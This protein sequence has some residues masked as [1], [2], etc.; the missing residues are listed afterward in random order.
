MVIL[1]LFFSFQVNVMT[2]T[3]RHTRLTV[4][5]MRR[6]ANTRLMTT[7]FCDNAVDTDV[8]VGEESV[9]IVE[10]VEHIGR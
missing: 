4:V 5:V 2:I 9:E 3:M 6:I 8:G 10:A 7:Q 1:D